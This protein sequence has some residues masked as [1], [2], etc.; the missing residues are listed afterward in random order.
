M[1]VYPQHRKHGLGGP[2]YSLLM[3]GPVVERKH[4]LVSLSAQMDL[5]IPRSS[6]PGLHPTAHDAAITGW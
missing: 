3:H 2:N 5:P 4:L 6:Q 1:R